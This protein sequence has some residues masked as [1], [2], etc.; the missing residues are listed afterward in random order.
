MNWR[1]LFCDIVTENGTKH[2]HAIVVVVLLIDI[3]LNLIIGLTPYI[4]NYN[5]TFA[6]VN[7]NHALS[8]I[9]PF[10]ISVA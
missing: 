1:L 4:D 5:R 7:L 2:R 9:M 8:N 3:V 6:L 10:Q